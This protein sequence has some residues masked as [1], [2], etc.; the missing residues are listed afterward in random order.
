MLE[1][2][3]ITFSLEMGDANAARTVALMQRPRRHAKILLLRISCLRSDLKQ[4]RENS[5][6]VFDSGYTVYCILFVSVKTTFILIWAILVS[7]WIDLVFYPSVVPSL[8]GL[9][10]LESQVN[11]VVYPSSSSSCFFLL[12]PLLQYIMLKY[13]RDVITIITGFCFG[14]MLLQKVLVRIT[15][16]TVPNSKPPN[17][18]WVQ[19]PLSSLDVWIEEFYVQLWEFDFG[20]ELL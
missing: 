20:S 19:I 8:C 7:V 11:D 9:F 16:L 12:I 3:L 2:E 17:L 15:L 4:I 13:V 6:H 10:G 14:S 1:L 5:V 18:V